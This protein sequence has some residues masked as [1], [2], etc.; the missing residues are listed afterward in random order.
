M[1]NVI[2]DRA[3]A[4]ED[5]RIMSWPPA[6]DWFG[7][8]RATNLV[9]PICS[10]A[11][12]LGQDCVALAGVQEPPR[13]PQGAGGVPR[14]G[15]AGRRTSKTAAPRRP[16]RRARK[17]S[18]GFL[19]VLLAVLCLWQA[20][21]SSQSRD[22]APA[23]LRK[24]LE[25]DGHIGP[26][27]L[28]EPADKFTLEQRRSGALLLHC[29]GLFYMF[30]ALAIVCDECFVPALEVITEVLD[31][32][33]DVAGATFMAAGGSAPEFFTSLIGA[34]VMESDI[35][36]GTI[37]GSAVFNVLFVIGACALIAPMPLHLTWFPLARDSLFYAVDLLVLS[38]FLLDERV[39]WYEA[40]IL[41]ILYLTYATFM[42]YSEGIEVWATGVRPGA[43]GKDDEAESPND[44]A[45]DSIEVVQEHLTCAAGTGEEVSTNHAGAPAGILVRSNTAGVG[46]HEPSR[47]VVRWSHSHDEDGKGNKFRHKSV[48]VAN[49]VT[50]IKGQELSKEDSTGGSGGTG[51]HPHSV[52]NRGDRCG[53][54]RS[55]SSRPEELGTGLCGTVESPK[56]ARSAPSE[57]K[58]TDVVPSQ[59]GHTHP[60][61]S[62][63]ETRATEVREKAKEPKV[64]VEEKVAEEV[65]E[66]GEEEKNEPLDFWPPRPW[67]EASARDRLSYVL[68]LPIV[69]LLVITVPDVRREGWRQYY[70]LTFAT[71]VLWIAGFT[72]AMVWFATVVAETCAV[73]EHI[74]GLTIL[75]AG[76]SVPDL[77][78]SMI[79][80]RQG[81]GDMAISSS[82]GS[83]IFDVTVG[84]PIPWLLYGWLHD[85]KSVKIKNEGL[86]INVMLLL[87]MLGFTVGTIVIHGW[88]MTKWMGASL[89]LLY[90][91]FEVVSIALT[92]APEGELKL[93]HVN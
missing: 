77:L 67:A 20:L 58:L 15:G 40:L 50:T 79:V 47:P 23:R 45:S 66:E 19:A 70:V 90:L 51:S 17:Y 5:C 36:T 35:G 18:L 28:A 24:V 11:E 91:V 55:S 26:R 33:P 25:D 6:G 59:D 37:I 68:T 88:V 14:A 31:L 44:E 84:L 29:V 49:H 87:G 2:R 10:P 48:R 8:K 7:A 93:I 52:D 32:S 39:K 43:G 42:K 34:L 80:A 12:E 72:W 63:S 38:C 9:A 62:S 78:T 89:L 60:A 65:G 57:W 4:D 27:S 61:S 56:Q 85:G 16:R 1:R 83:N 92:F 81:H 53:P 21:R 75:A 64:V 3:D 69:F 71:S 30:G 82:I 74:M 46:S 73:E 86:E 76:T 22:G 41:F 54:E 13:R